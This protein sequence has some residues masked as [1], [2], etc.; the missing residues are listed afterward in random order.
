MI[1][2][3]DKTFCVSQTCDRHLNTLN[4]S[5]LKRIIIP[6]SMADFECNKAEQQTV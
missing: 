2:Y 3:K 1:N 4:K 6:L 5:E